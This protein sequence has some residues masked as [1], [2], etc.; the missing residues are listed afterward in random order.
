MPQEGESPLVSDRGLQKEVLDWCREILRCA[1]KSA[2]EP[3]G[4]DVPGLGGV[5]V[6][7]KNSGGLRGCIGRFSWE[8]PLKS[9]IA[10]LTR[11]SAFE[12]YRF[13]P[14]TAPELADLEI[15]VSVLSPPE[16][17]D[18]LDSLV[19]GRDGLILLHP[20][21]KGVL[22]PVVAEE[23]GWGPR[24]FA[25]H[26]SRKAGLNPDAYLDPAAQLLVFRAPAF[27]TSDFQA[28]TEAG[29]PPAG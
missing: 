20:R 18:S 5:F 19:I 11:A 10:D 21:G 1:L 2:P 4:P 7:L 27:S 12:D 15:T 17:L 29:S 22:L 28:D 9:T 25:E 13:P 23:Y 3:P 14:L 26:T 6:T 16:P 24:E 8:M